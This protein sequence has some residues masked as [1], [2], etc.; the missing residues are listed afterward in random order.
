PAST[1]YRQTHSIPLAPAACTARPSK[2]TQYKRVGYPAMRVPVCPDNDALTRRSVIITVDEPAARGLPRW[3]A[4]VFCS[5]PH[6]PATVP[7][8]GRTMGQGHSSPL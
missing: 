5:R 7:R 3:L 6:G 4:L 8:E 1:K 2:A